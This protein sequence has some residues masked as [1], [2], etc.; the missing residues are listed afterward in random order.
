[1]SIELSFEQRHKAQKICII[2]NFINGIG[3]GFVV[4]DIITLIALYYHANSIQMGILF[5]ALYATFPVALIAPKILGGRDCTSVWRIAWFLRALI[6]IAYFFIGYLPT[7]LQPWLIVII[8]YIFCALRSI[9]VSANLTVYS[10]IST[11]E[12]R[13]SFIARIFR[14]LY[15][16][17]LIVA[18]SS[19]LI[20]NY[21]VFGLELS[22]YLGLVALGFIF[23]FASTL[24]LFYIP[25]TASLP[26]TNL[27]D[28]CHTIHEILITSKYRHVIILSTIHNI[29]MI[30]CSYS[31]PYLK[32]SVGITSSQVVLLFL[33]GLVGGV[34]ATQLLHYLGNKIN[35]WIATAFCYLLTFGGMVFLA[36]LSCNNSQFCYLY[37]IL[38]M[39]LVYVG[40]QTSTALLSQIQSERL[41]AN[42]RYLF[43]AVYQ[44]SGIISVVLAL[45]FVKSAELI[46]ELH[47]HSGDNKYLL[48]FIFCCML[49]II[50][51]LMC[52]RWRS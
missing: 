9:G 20:I 2:Q 13:G 33:S 6:L 27:R 52:R 43:S 14:S 25:P 17:F 47:W 49:S 42:N 1:M 40:K 36:A 16:S 23:S 50:C 45:S 31:I 10:L 39:V 38:P 22:N 32:N 8:S 37:Y 46:S 21:H 5:G 26:N 44:L 35:S 15:A 28:V 3:V 30:L 12:E 18:V 41:S 11:A 51:A 19:Y 34:F 4:G 29:I 7:A 48:I 24:F